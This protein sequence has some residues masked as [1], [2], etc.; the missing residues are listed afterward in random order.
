MK[1]YSTIQFEIHSF[2]FRQPFIDGCARFSVRYSF[3]LFPI[4]DRKFEPLCW[5]D[6]HLN[7][8]YSIQLYFTL[9]LIHTNN[10]KRNDITL[11]KYIK[12]AFNGQVYGTFI[13]Q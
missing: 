12:V 1:T 2:L 10:E 9:Q 3:H 13:V 6:F 11:N 5:M 8:Y 7:C 4:N